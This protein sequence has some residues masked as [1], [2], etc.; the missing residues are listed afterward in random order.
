MNTNSLCEES[1][2]YAKLHLMRVL[3]L[4]SPKQANV[5]AVRLDRDMVTQGRDAKEA[6]A[7]L[8]KVI[9]A[10]DLFDTRRK[11]SSNKQPRP[12]PLVYSK[13]YGI[14]AIYDGA[15]PKDWEVRIWRGESPVQIKKTK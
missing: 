6:M 5:V 13:L 11:Y 4:H 8:E 1:N 3:L 9:K 14:S 15:V 7:A 12:A 2:V 10:T